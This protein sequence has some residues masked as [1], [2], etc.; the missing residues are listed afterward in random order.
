[1]NELIK[2]KEWRFSICIVMYALC[3]ALLG[4]VCINAHS[5]GN[6]LTGECGDSARYIFDT[7]TGLLTISGSGSFYCPQ[8]QDLISN[9]K[10]D[11]GITEIPD[12]AFSNCINLENV[13]IPDSVT[14]IGSHAFSECSS[15]NSIDIPI[16]VEEIEAFAFEG[17][18]NLM[19]VNIP[20]DSLLIYISQGAFRD[21]N[22]LSQFVVPYKNRGVNLS[23]SVFEGCDSLY[24]LTLCGMSL[25]DFCDLGCTNLKKLTIKPSP[26]DSG[27]FIGKEEVE[28]YSKLSEIVF[29]FHGYG[30]NYLEIMSQLFKNNPT[31]FICSYA[32]T[33]IH[34]FDS[35]D[36]VPYI[37][38]TEE[39]DYAVKNVME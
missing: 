14:R 32:D 9:V 5:E 20:E 16:S 3:C 21:C 30:N 17:C 22:R 25:K 24:D 36:E 2:R 33:K 11:E 7:E 28:V 39:F 18:S 37:E 4:C 23:T 6:I 10:I 38:G 19:A 12:W 31:M 15:L 13:S 27:T 29:D 1:M 34:I 26:W 8:N 35:Y